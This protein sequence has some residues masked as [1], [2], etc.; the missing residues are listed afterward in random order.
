MR[1]AGRTSHM[2]VTQDV[3]RLLAEVQ[4]LPQTELRPL[5]YHRYFAQ[6]KGEVE[7]T[8]VLNRD[9]KAQTIDLDWSG[10]QLTARRL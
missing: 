3:D 2:R 6:M 5:A 7:L 1:F 10:H 9:G 4:G 8:F